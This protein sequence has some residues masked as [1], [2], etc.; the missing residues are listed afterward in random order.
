MF[1]NHILVPYD[2]SIQSEKAL[3]DAIQLT[4]VDA[5]VTLE[6]IYVRY[7]PESQFLDEDTY[8]QINEKLNKRE[9][10]IFAKVSYK[11]SQF[12]NSKITKKFGYPS[13]VILN[14]IKNT[15][16]DLVI[17][18]QSGIGG[19]KHFFGSVSHRIIHECTVPIL[20]IK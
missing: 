18:G 5:S 6:V 9:E 4:K 14:H 16:I 11:I 19:I 13:E 10:K 3:N 20:V 2:G 1:Y 8:N 15:D 7:M 17:I 12:A